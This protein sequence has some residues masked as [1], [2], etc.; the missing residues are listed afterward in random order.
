MIRCMTHPIAWPAVGLKYQISGSQRRL[1]ISRKSF[2]AH[3]QQIYI[4]IGETRRERAPDA[5]G[6]MNVGIPR[7]V[8]V[9]FN[10]DLGA[11]ALQSFA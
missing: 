7:T 9:F 11:K 3:N 4:W 5:V 1:A 2:R 6:N 8:V 10:H